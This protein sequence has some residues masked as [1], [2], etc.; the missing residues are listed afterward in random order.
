MS[1]IRFCIAYRLID[2]D[3]FGNQQSN[4]IRYA[5][6]RQLGLVAM[7]QN[8]YFPGSLRPDKVS[9]DSPGSMTGGENFEIDAIN[10]IGIVPWRPDFGRFVRRVSIVAFQFALP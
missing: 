8:D 6:N 4:D 2:S 1:P 9:D 7:C 5:L 3:I 10:I